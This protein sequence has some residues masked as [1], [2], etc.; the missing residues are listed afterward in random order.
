[1]YLIIQFLFKQVTYGDFFTRVATTLIQLSLYNISYTILQE[2]L[3][4][5]NIFFHKVLGDKYGNAV[6]FIFMKN[7][8]L[9]TMK[10]VL[11]V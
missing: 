1:M 9:S 2:I 10:P 4:I 5:L 6:S 11:V 3:I 7:F 8:Q